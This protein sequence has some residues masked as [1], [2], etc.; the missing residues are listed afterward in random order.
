MLG[1]EVRLLSEKTFSHT[2]SSPY[3]PKSYPPGSHSAYVSQIIT[4][5]RENEAEYLSEEQPCKTGKSSKKVL[6]VQ[7]HTR[8]FRVMGWLL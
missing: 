5:D 6:S 3:T 8:C 7:A 1:L 2:E 4:E